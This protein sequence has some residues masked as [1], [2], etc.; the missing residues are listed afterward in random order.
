[1]VRREPP[2]T[3]E[4][5]YAFHDL[6]TVDWEAW[7]DAPERVRERALEEAVEF[8][9]SAEAVDDAE[10][11]DSA[12]YA[13]VGHKADLMVVHLR[14]SLAD[15]ER[16]ERRFER[17]EF[18]QFTEQSSSYV[19]VTEAS[20]YSERASEYF[21]GEVDD[22]SGLAQYIQSR[23]HPEIP[24]SEH[25]SFYPMSKRRQPDQNWYDLPF[26]ER[27]EHMESHGDIGRDYA[28]RVSQMITGS[29]GMDD[30]EWGVTLWADDMTDVKELLYEMRFDP[31]S[32]K[33]ADFGPFYVGRK[34]PPADLD[35][36]LAGES[37]PTA[38]GA[39]ESS[40]GERAAHASASGAG[41]D[42][43][44]GGGTHANGDHGAR[45]DSESADPPAESH[46]GGADDGEPEAVSESS[47]GGASGGRPAAAQKD[48][49]AEELDADEAA[50]TLA[51]FGV[52][53]E[54]YGAGDYAL[55]CYADADAEELVDEVDG[56]R[57]NFD[58]YDT[59]VL[60][61]VRANGGQT[62]VVSVWDN[63]GAADTAL[64]FLTDIDGV[65]H[66]A[67][68]PLGDAGEAGPEESEASGDEAADDESDTTAADIRAELADEGVYAG[69]PHGEDV[70]ALVLYSEADAETLDA[71]VSDLR[72]GFDRYDT[73]VK[74]AV[75]TD[76]D[77]DSDT[78]A[79]VSLWDTQSAADTAAD[80]LT[81]LPEIVGRPQERE[82]F[83]TMG[84]FYTVKP[85]YREEFVD[86][87]GT[88]GELLAEMDGHRETAL[89]A[90]R[91]DDADMFI[92][93]RWDAKEDAMAFFRSED[94][95]E[96]VQ[97]GREVLADRPRHVF[98]A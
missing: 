57:G 32:S 45:S 78:T 31:S 42:G 4:G 81:D 11:G 89:L 34:F 88:V 17:T 80:F 72:D 96:T 19:S 93:S 38:D 74:T 75:Y 98:L 9:G 90:N 28:G 83:G 86:T 56:L 59:H 60:T 6:R 7:R 5:W 97:W 21:D 16:L 70:Y 14:P 53:P 63:E 12:L 33:F 44:A 67:R 43:N 36:Y 50:Q 47:E 40:A 77:S 54:D 48:V 64:G 87:F 18:A 13:V 49:D 58:H 76:T 37:V 91:E 66:S 85:D 29:V 52:Y 3:E 22:D 65:T 94:F 30:W 1:M 41:H 51:N 71:E 27:A 39:S 61:S 25:V 46:A 69:Q 95:R 73:H 84:M 82:G 15:T 26:E 8:L 23:L 2:Q 24:D 68:G 92:A 35:A 62:A 10:A 20:G 79:V 55:V